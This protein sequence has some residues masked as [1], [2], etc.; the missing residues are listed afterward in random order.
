M[1][2]KSLYPPDIAKTLE[3]NC[4]SLGIPRKSVMPMNSQKS[5]PLDC[6]DGERIQGNEDY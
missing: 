2:T 3:S 4:F 6:G 5:S 1:E